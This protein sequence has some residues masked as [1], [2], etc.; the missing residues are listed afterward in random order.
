MADLKHL[1]SAFLFVCTDLL[2]SDLYAVLLHFQ[3]RLR[4][5]VLMSLCGLGGFVDVFV[6]YMRVDHG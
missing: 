6:W 4:S 5:I 2:V 1:L 3:L